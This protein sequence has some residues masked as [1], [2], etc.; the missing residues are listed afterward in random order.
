[1]IKN[2]LKKYKLSIIIA[3]I[4][5]VLG[6]TILT[7]ISGLKS[8]K[9]KEY[10]NNYYKI[11]YDRTWSLKEK[12]E[13]KISLKNKYNAQIEINII[14]ISDEKKYSPIEDLIDEI[15]YN[16]ENQNSSYK[17]LSKKESTLTQYDY[18]GYKLLYENGENQA[19][20]AIYKKS[21][22]IIMINYEAPNK[23][24]DILLDSA[25]NIIYYFDTKEDTYELSYKINAETTDY[26]YPES[27][28]LDKV[29]TND[30]T[31]E[32]AD[33]NYYVKYSIPSC[34]AL[35]DIKTTYH[36]FNLEGIEYKNLSISTQI[37][38]T[39]I[40]ELIEKDNTQS[41]YRDNKAYRDN[42]EYTNIEESLTKLDDALGG[43]LYYFG[44]TFKGYDF[45]ED[46]DIKEVDKRRESIVLLYPLNFNHTLLFNIESSDF[47]ITKKLIDSI[48]ILDVK[49]YSSY[50]TS[51]EE[52]GYLV[53]KIST[54]YDTDKKQILE[55]TVKLPNKYK[56]Y[57]DYNDVSIEKKYYLN[58]NEDRELYDYEIRYK[59]YENYMDTDKIV[60]MVNTLFS[61]AYGEYHYLTQT[62]DTTINDKKLLT[63][64]GGYTDSGGIMLTNKDRFNYYVNKTLLIYGLEN[65]GYLTIEISGNDH[66]ITEDIIKEAT[67]FEINKIDNK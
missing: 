62:N 29:L 24:F 6:M 43:Y 25:E 44:Y 5:I 21:E 39:N 41:V 33:N 57:Q 1:M 11:I 37:R 36:H 27:E 14:E 48:K 17:L 54:F 23:Y 49:N 26:K 16:L 31:Y 42:E 30:K 67:N 45:G 53:G 4:I 2:I 63:Y 22:K 40:Y 7:I 28:E 50:V 46:F 20:S 9:L 19:M 60:E 61:K 58:Y 56:E 12:K 59:M 32:I 38:K 35:S 10:E 52:D 55:T 13:D 8:N 65:G 34:F 51:K 64:T 66:P 15:T 18:K 47:P 3:L